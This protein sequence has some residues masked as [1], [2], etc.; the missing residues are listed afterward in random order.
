MKGFFNPSNR[1]IVLDNILTR[2]GSEEPMGTVQAWPRATAG[3]NAGALRDQRL[4]IPREN[5]LSR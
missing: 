5:L 1:T 3:C 4:I 2:G